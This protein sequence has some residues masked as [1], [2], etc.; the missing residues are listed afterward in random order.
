MKSIISFPKI[1]Q[2]LIYGTAPNGMRITIS[3]K[4]AR[5]IHKKFI[6]DVINGQGEKVPCG[7]IPFYSK[8]IKKE[9]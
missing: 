4:T 2:P 5:I 8:E 3:R 7:L 9:K 1:K 6:C